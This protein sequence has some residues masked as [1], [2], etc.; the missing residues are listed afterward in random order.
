MLKLL[1][2]QNTDVAGLLEEGSQ[3]Y[4]CMPVCVSACVSVATSMRELACLVVLVSCVF[5]L[6]SDGVSDGLHCPW[7]RIPVKVMRM[8]GVIPYSP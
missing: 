1:Q 6:F 5:I 4:L 3:L 7:P 2:S 8:F